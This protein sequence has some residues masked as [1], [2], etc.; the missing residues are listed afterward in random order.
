M[1]RIL[2]VDPSPADTK[3][4]KQKFVDETGCLVTVAGRTTVGLEEINTKHKP[5]VDFLVLEIDQPDT[6]DLDAIAKFRAVS[7][8]PML[9]LA[10]TVNSIH[11]FKS[12]NLGADE[13]L[14]KKTFFSSDLAI[15][16]LTIEE[17]VR[18]RTTLR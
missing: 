10:E 16:L 9:V 8:L 17:R 6:N 3:Q 1:K 2:I 7:D 18:I 15:L 12:L 14:D 4:I 11:L 13:Y 5:L